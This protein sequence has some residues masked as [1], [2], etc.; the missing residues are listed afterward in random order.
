M[1]TVG[2]QSVHGVDAFGGVALIVLGFH[3]QR[4]HAVAERDSAG[5]VDLFN[6][7]LH[8][9]FNVGSVYGEASGQGAD[10]PQGDGVPFTSAA[11]VPIGCSGSIRLGRVGLGPAGGEAERQTDGKKQG[12]QVF[13]FHFLILQS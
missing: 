11:R 12:Q 2:D 5:S 1:D 9:F 6:G 3:G 13:Q 10:H 7:K 4:M 8:A